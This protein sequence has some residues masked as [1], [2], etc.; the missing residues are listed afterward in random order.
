MINLDSARLILTDQSLQTCRPV[1]AFGVRRVFNYE[2][3]TKIDRYAAATHPLAR[4]ALNVRL[5]GDVYDVV[6]GL[7]IDVSLPD[8]CAFR[9]REIGNDLVRIACLDWNGQEQPPFLS[10]IL[11]CPEEPRNG[12]THINDEITPHHDYYLKCRSGAREVEADFLQLWLASTYLADGVTP[13]AQW[14]TDVFPE[15]RKT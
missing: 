3:S 5:T 7:H 4:A 6:N 14:E 15:L 13:V 2:I 8:L 9:A 12:I 10:Y 1:V 11:R